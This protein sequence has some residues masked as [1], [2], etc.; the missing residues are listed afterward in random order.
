MQAGAIGSASARMPSAV[1][2]L[3]GG[4]C[5]LANS[6][7]SRAVIAVSRIRGNVIIASRSRLRQSGAIAGA[8]SRL[9]ARLEVPFTTRDLKCHN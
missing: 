6:M 4:V 8:R 3:G 9:A 5:A 7:E 2:A 1:K